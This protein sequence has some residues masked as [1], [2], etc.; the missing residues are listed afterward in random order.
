MATGDMKNNIRKLIGELRQVSYDIN[1]IDY[2][3]II[4]GITSAFLPMMHHIF[5]DYSPNIASY[6]TAKNYELYAKTD[7]RFVET[8][9]KILMKEFSYKP[10]LTKEQFLALGFAERKVILLVDIVKFCRE[11]NKAISNEKKKPV[12]KGKSSLEKVSSNQSNLKVSSKFSG[13]LANEVDAK[14]ER[15]VINSIPINERPFLSSTK[16]DKILKRNEGASLPTISPS[17]D[18]SSRTKGQIPIPD[19]EALGWSNK[20]DSDNVIP[21]PCGSLIVTPLKDVEV[22]QENA[23]FVSAKSKASIIEIEDIEPNFLKTIDHRNES[24][25]PHGN[26]HKNGIEITTCGSGDFGKDSVKQASDFVAF[27]QDVSGLASQSDCLCSCNSEK[28]Q[29]L[30]NQMTSLETSLKDLVTINN[31]LSARI[32][33]LETH[34]I[35]MEKR[36]ESLTSTT[37]CNQ[38]SCRPATPGKSMTDQQRSDEKLLKH[39]WDEES[40]HEQ[41]LVHKYSPDKYAGYCDSVPEDFQPIM[42]ATTTKKNNVNDRE[43]QLEYDESKVEYGGGQ[44]FTVTGEKNE[45]AANEKAL[46]YDGK[47]EILSPLHENEF[48][49]MEEQPWA[50]VLNL[51]KKLEETMDL[52][53][54]NKK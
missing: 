3:A 2:D 5:L 19:L 26:V 28:V 1:N 22:T 30:Q 24:E 29:K 21:K 48:S 15:K 41:K 27:K 11:K 39:K 17:R 16:R 52:F 20:S 36:I 32:V 14:Q 10:S 37:N 49:F 35:L 53:N 51:Q 6:L 23:E 8:V 43:K 47:E 33:L 18:E 44:K 42:V 7:L 34:N 46:H 40:A 12:R 25:K 45:M 9:Y 50:T 4:H 13:K 54:S 38:V 31:E